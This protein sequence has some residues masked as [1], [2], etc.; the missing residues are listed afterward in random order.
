MTNFFSAKQVPAGL[1]FNATPA[2]RVLRTPSHSFH[3]RQRPWQ[4]Q[5][6]MIAPV[7]AGE[8]LENLLMQSRVVS[9]PIK[10]PL[11]GWWLEYYYYFVPLR[12]ISTFFQENNIGSPGEIGSSQRSVIERMLLDFNSPM[13]AVTY[14]SSSAKPTLYEYDANG[15]TGNQVQWLNYITQLVA[16][17]H[18]RDEGDDPSTVDSLPLV[19]LAGNSWTDSVYAADQFP[20]ETVDVNATPTPDNFSVEEMNGMY[21]TWLAMRSQTMSELTFEDYVQTFGVRQSVGDELAPELIR[22]VRNWSYPT[23]TIGTSGDDLGVP[24]SALSWSV[25]ERADKKRFFREPGFIVGFSC[26]RP[27]V[28]I[29]AQRTYASAMLADAFSWMP[30]VYKENVEFSLKKI[31]AGE[32]PLGTAT[33]R[34]AKDYIVDLRDLFLYGD[35]FLN[36]AMTETD[37]N[38]IAG[39]HTGDMVNWGIK[40]PAS[41]DL[42]LLFANASPLN[43]IR[44]D[45][46]VNLRIKGTQ[47]DH[48]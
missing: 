39:P 5:P 46:V 13:D 43:K 34:A 22:Y 20:D 26:V 1:G 25:S 19:K 18:F 48:T 2:K 32:G 23:N 12:Y 31:E 9:D 33:Y 7:L 30:A 42:D 11:I 8:T 29:K 28:Y 15:E 37:A 6:C 47:V 14:G 36:F 40:Y 44:Q 3:L 21:Q 35:Q 27:K 16:A 24:S 38:I 41:T 45:G 4:L 17:Y 10:N